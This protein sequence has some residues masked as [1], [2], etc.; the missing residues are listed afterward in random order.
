M[1]VDTVAVSGAES[2]E[3]TSGVGQK[4]KRPSGSAD[5]RAIATPGAWHGCLLWLP[6]KARYC[7]VGRMP[8]SEFC[9]VH[10]E[11]RE[12][13]ADKPARKRIPCPH[14]PTHN[15]FED[16]KMH[17][18]RTCPFLV[19]AR[20]TEALPCFI[21]GCNLG[22]CPETEKAAW[23]AFREIVGSG[24][25]AD[26]AVATPSLV[27][28]PHADE[29]GDEGEHAAPAGTAGKLHKAVEGVHM[30]QLRAHMQAWFESTAS[31]FIP[32]VAA[33][34]CGEQS[35]DTPAAEP[36]SEPS[37][38][39]QASGSVVGATATS[40]V[41][42]VP[43]AHVKRGALAALAANRHDLQSEAIVRFMTDAGMLAPGLLN[44]ECGAGS[45]ALSEAL[46]R[47]HSLP[48]RVRCKLALVE[49]NGGTSRRDAEIKELLL[50]GEAAVRAPP[51]A[52]ENW[53]PRG[54]PRGA[55]TGAGAANK[56][57]GA[58]ATPTAGSD[59]AAAGADVVTGQAAPAAEPAPR[60]GKSFTAALAQPHVQALLNDCFA[61]LRIDLADFSLA[62]HPAFQDAC[63][64]VMPADRVW[65]EYNTVVMRVPAPVTAVDGGASDAAVAT[66]SAGSTAGVDA[67]SAATASTFDSTTGPACADGPTAASTAA[68]AGRHCR[69]AVVFAKHLCGGA[70]DITLRCLSNALIGAA[71]TFRIAGDV[72]E[73]DDDAAG[74]APAVTTAAP[75]AGGAAQ[76]GAAA[77]AHAGADGATTAQP[78]PAGLAGFGGVAIATCCHHQCE[79]PLFVG[80]RL[81]RRECPDALLTL[82][83]PEGSAAASASG[84]ADGGSAG[85][86]EAGSGSAAAG[87]QTRTA[88]LPRLFET[89]RL[90]SSWANTFDQS[91]GSAANQRMGNG[92][93][94]MRIPLP[95]A[96]GAGAGAYAGESAGATAGAG[97][98][99]SATE[100]LAEEA[101][102][103]EVPAAD[104]AECPTASDDDVGPYSLPAVEKRQLGRACKRLID[105]GRCDFLQRVLHRAAELDAERAAA[106]G[107]HGAAAGSAA[108]ALPLSVA[109]RYFV[110]TSYTPEN[111]LL[112][113]GKAPIAC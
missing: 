112:L 5:L 105:A 102:E 1:D 106:A 88:L 43:S 55:A 68:A 25:T 59:D 66:P 77:T 54:A 46:V 90:V 65:Q 49:R 62:H 95:A 78:Q 64:A 110:P 35:S 29:A 108:P 10:T 51:V 72:S 104:A 53:R 69:P 6:K 14:D 22:T 4:R 47:A 11:N 37:K 70:T 24:E 94:N 93:R 67:A 75:A 15:I 76:S 13:T 52:P 18:A 8:G 74:A 107:G 17:I 27:G 73:H 82:L 7:S 26:S 9:G 34:H 32:R 23:D 41:A 85:G 16:A 91:A 84:V 92:R 96:A 57:K 31:R 80:K 42:P 97:A 12:A 83:Q 40:T 71:E 38:V 44:V 113:A 48:R 20:A 33:E 58:A 3:A 36:V 39:P 19:K 56:G 28:R 89:M 101:G 30:P 60:Q 21:Q 61:R 100:L 45:A 98:A 50:E 111:C 87:A 99:E 103:M 63:S 2:A 109:L 79:W 81:F 86:A